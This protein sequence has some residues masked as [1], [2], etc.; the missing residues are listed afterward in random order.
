[1]SAAI[2]ILYII[3]CTALIATIAVQSSNGMV[4]QA[5]VPRNNF[6]SRETVLRRATVILSV[7]VL[8]LTLLLVFGPM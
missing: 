1:M 7:I 2:Y 4:K 6:V 3:M 8:A 5:A